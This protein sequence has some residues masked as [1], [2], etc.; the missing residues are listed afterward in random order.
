MKPWSLLI[1]YLCFPFILMSQQSQKDSLFDVYN[2]RTK[3]LNERNFALRELM[4]NYYLFTQPDSAYLLTEPALQNAEKDHD[5]YWMIRFS[6]IMG[7]SLAIRGE[8]EK[9]LEM[10]LK[11]LD[12]SYEHDNSAD[13]GTNLTYVGNIYLKIGNYPLGIKYHMDALK[14]FESVKDNDNITAS[15]S[16]IGNIYSSINDFENALIYYE[17]GLALSKEISNQTRIGVL[18]HNLG[19]IYEKFDE[20]EKALF[21]FQESLVIKEKDNYQIGIS[22]T[23]ASIGNIH[24]KLKRFDEADK[25]LNRALELSKKTGSRDAECTTKIYLANRHIEG[26]NLMKSLDF[27]K[28]AYSLAKQLKDKTIIKNASEILYRVYKALGKKSEALEMYEY[29]ISVRDTIESEENNREI[30]SQQYQY[31]YEKK[32]AIAKIEQEKKDAITLARLQRQKTIR[33][34]SLGGFSLMFISAFIFFRQRN[35]IKKE[36]ATSEKLLLNILPSEVAEELKT[37]G[38]AEAKHFDQVSVLFTD[39]KQFTKIAEKLS[40]AE[41]VEEIDICFQAF[42]RIMEKYNIEKIKTIGDAY[43]A[44]GGL[45][46]HNPDHAKDVV[47]AALE[48]RD[49]MLEK[50]INMKCRRKRSLKS[51]LAFIQDQ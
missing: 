47:S 23:L 14:I 17:K 41:L 36:K 5:L 12:W 10:F 48:I 19:T 15:Y 1:A 7:I 45:P 26:G 37:K 2:N 28:D 44:A 8:N 20:F 9:A 31:D 22:T 24:V 32:E 39:F 18:H 16:V 13:I 6:S 3:E 50:K 51:G 25:Y 34:A 29:F 49:F 38:K 4:F 35:N 21:H 43:M 42:D 33:N 30:I 11:S 40:P 46:Q 27:A